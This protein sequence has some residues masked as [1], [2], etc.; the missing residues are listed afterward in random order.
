MAQGDLEI[1]HKGTDDMWADVDTK[2]TQGKA[3]LVIPGEVM[4]VSVE[5]DDDVEHRRTHPLLK[6]K[7]ESE[8]ISAAD[9]EIL[10]KVAIVV[11]ARSPA[12]KPKREFCRVIEASRFLRE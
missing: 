3:F 12:K 5:Y 4:G 1:Q 6:Q 10:E 7:I 11:P 9:G 2:P 8:R